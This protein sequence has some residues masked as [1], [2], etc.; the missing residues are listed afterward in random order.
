MADCARCGRKL[1]ALSFGKVCSYC[2]QAEETDI[3]PGGHVSQLVPAWRV[4]PTVTMAIVAVN[5]AVFLAMTLGGVSLMGGDTQQLIQWGADKG[6]YTFGGESWRAISSAFVHIG[7]IHIG[8]NMWCLWNLGRM[9]EQ[10]YDKGTYIGAYLL[11]GIGGSIASLAW[12]PMAVTA[13]ASGAIFGIAGLLITTFWMG[14]LPI[15]REQTSAIMRS[16]LGF[17]GYNLLFGAAI[18]GISNSAHMGGLFT[19]LILGG[20]MAPSLTRDPRRSRGLR[21]LIL[22]GATVALVVLFKFAQAR[23]VAEYAQ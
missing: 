23:F 7:I 15:P 8:M 19:G 20:L 12:Q 3:Q 18:P 10:I 21:W 13:G 11:C 6:P 1:P 22:A 2:R 4:G 14:N 16:L 9:A 17:A 5:A